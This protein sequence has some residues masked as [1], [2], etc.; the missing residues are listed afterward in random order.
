MGRCGRLKVISSGSIG[1]CYLLEC[2]NESLILELGV[3]WKD[4]LKALN[5]EEGL[6]KVRGCLTSHL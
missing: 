6:R 1:N 3:T 4:I 5:F 2:S